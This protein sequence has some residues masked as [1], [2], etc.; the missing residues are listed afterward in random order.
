MPDFENIEQN[1]SSSIDSLGLDEL[2]VSESNWKERSLEDKIEY[3]KDI[4]SKIDEIQGKTGLS[5]DE[6]FNAYFP[7]IKTVWMGWEND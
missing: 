4:D 5:K 2:K 7:E 1:T 3:V 6:I